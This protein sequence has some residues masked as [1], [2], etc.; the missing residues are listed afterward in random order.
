MKEVNNARNALKTN[1]NPPLLL[2]LAPDLSTD[3]MSEI[4]SVILKKETKVDG[5]IISNTTIDRPQLQNTE[6]T[7]EAGGLSGKPLTVKSTEMI[8]QMYKMTKGSYYIIVT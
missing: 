3:E 7:N 2:K 4:V 5:L 8:K 1:N 6:F